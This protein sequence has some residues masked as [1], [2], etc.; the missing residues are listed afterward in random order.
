MKSGISNGRL[1]REEVGSN[2]WRARSCS[3]SVR[4]TKTGSPKESIRDFSS[5][6]M[7]GSWRRSFKV[8][9]LPKKSFFFFFGF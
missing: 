8:V 3:S 5:D 9:L 4:P 7:L 1:P 2:S 6:C